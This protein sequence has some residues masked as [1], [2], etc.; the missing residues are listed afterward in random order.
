MRS[1]DRDPT[2]RQ[3]RMLS[4]RTLLSAGLG[5]VATAACGFPEP[6]ASPQDDYL[7]SVRLNRRVIGTARPFPPP[8]DRRAAPHEIA[9]S[10]FHQPGELTINATGNEKTMALRVNYADHDFVMRDLDIVR[11][12][13]R[14]YNGHT[15]GPTIRCDPGD[16]LNIT[17]TNDLPDGESFTYDYEDCTTANDGR[18]LTAS[19][20]GLPHGFNTTNLHT[21]GLHVS[22]SSLCGSQQCAEPPYAEPPTL[23]SD[24]IFVEVPPGHEQ[25]YSIV[26]PDFHAPGTHWYHAHKHGS[27]SLQ[28][29]NGLV[30]ALIVREQ[31]DQRILGD[32]QHEDYVF[33]IQEFTEAGNGNDQLVY[34]MGRA[35]E[36]QFHVN[37]LFR[38]PMRMQ[39]GEIQRW[40]FINA[41]STP[42]GLA[43]LRLIK[44]PVDPPPDTSDIELSPV[45]GRGLEDEQRNPTAAA[46]SEQPELFDRARVFQRMA[47]DEARPM[48]LIAVDG[49]SFYGK[50]PREVLGWDLAPG[51]RADFLVRIDEP[52]QYAIV[53]DVHPLGR[54]ETQ[55]LA[56]VEVTGGTRTMELPAVIPGE[57]PCYLQPIDS[58]DST[59]V[60]T[61]Q[62]A[63][64][65]RWDSVCPG[66]ERPWTCAGE[67]ITC[68]GS[69]RS[70][71]P[72]APG[73]P[74]LSPRIFAMDCARFDPEQ[75][76]AKYVV[77][78]NTAEEWTLRNRAG[79]GH[80]FHIHVNPFQVVETF[81]GR[82]RLT[83]NA[84]DAVW[85]DVVAVPLGG[86]VKIRQR[87]LTFAGDFVIHCHF[88]NHEDMGM[89]KRVRVVPSARAPGQLPCRRVRECLT[90]GGRGIGESRA[91]ASP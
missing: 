8:R 44:L 29:N 86:Y 70:C 88:L 78:L 77:E 53:K 45:G 7:E 11:G 66:T 72:T 90:A 62:A 58:V 20:A 40:R 85:Q 34:A 47:A 15:P 91:P 81:D 46:E 12:K 56:T 68:S 13:V 3:P 67:N 59:K 42:R 49:I 23:A 71:N 10:Y 6:P 14:A 57:R 54:P 35:D 87:Y 31:G 82:E 30:G 63:A 50:A 79:A 22:P 75:V 39:T 80:P 36:S 64:S 25:Q 55:Y 74:T 43:K 60:V 38:P 18:V 1:E 41:T 33:L 84:G 17:L 37:G 4:R 32:E 83:F 5:G 52:G 51:N 48:N 28:V 24:D 21:H 89:M 2:S 26:L 27:T 69:A 61:F 65:G 19:E 76:E 73:M 16:R 9:P